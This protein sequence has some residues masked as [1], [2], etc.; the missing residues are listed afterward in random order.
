MDTEVILGV[1]TQHRQ[2]GRS[3]V[4]GGIEYSLRAW[5]CTLHEGR[6]RSPNPTQLPYIKKVEFILHETFEN[7][8]RA[9]KR[10]STAPC[11]HNVVVT[12]APFKVGEE[13]WGEFDL[14]IIVHFINCSETY[15]IVHDLNFH[16]GESYMKKYS[17]TIPDP[18]PGFLVLFNKH[19]SVSRKTIPPRATKARK[20]PPRDSAYA[21]QLASSR[22][23]SHSDSYSSDRSGASD[24]DTGSEDERGA[25]DSESDRRTTSSKTQSVSS[26]SSR[27]G[28][29]RVQIID[30]IHPST[31]QKHIPRDVPVRTPKARS[32]QSSAKS[33]KTVTPLSAQ[34]RRQK[35]STQPFV[36]RSSSGIIRQKR[37]PPDSIK[38][39]ISAASNSSNTAT[40]RVPLIAS[41]SP[42]LGAATA[43][44]VSA[45]RRLSNAG[46]TASREK[47]IS[48]TNKLDR[49]PPLQASSGIKRRLSDALDNPN[50]GNGA[51]R[52]RTMANSDTHTISSSPPQ[53]IETA[54]LEHNSTALK[55]SVLG[56]ISGVK[57]PKKQGVKSVAP[58]APAND[59]QGERDRRSV[60][61]KRS[62]IANG[63]THTSLLQKS[64]LRNDDEEQNTGLS[65]REA[66]VRERERQ[67]HLEHMRE[68]GQT[69]EPISAAATASI[70]GPRT[71]KTLPGA[72]KGSRNGS[73]A[74]SVTKNGRIIDTVSAA[75]GEEDEPYGA[76]GDSGKRKALRRDL[77]DIPIPKQASKVGPAESGSSS[78]I[79]RSRRASS[80]EKKSARTA[81]D[82][83]PTKSVKLMERIMERASFLN[84]S[85]LIAFLQLLHSL[86]V[87]Q[88]PDNAVSITDEAVDRVE[89]SGEYACN[90]STLK[91]MAIDRLWTFIKETCV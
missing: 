54:R 75:D 49:Q 15:K 77:L 74:P 29:N 11:L 63:N 19:S 17:F 60:A 68:S 20:G 82:T 21:K 28:Q 18:T 41:R 80:A 87:E 6:P 39:S 78:S 56:G 73:T 24:D 27:H 35:D 32:V 48:P 70:A 1:H 34:H 79:G 85:E 16:E 64:L 42:T 61:E 33:E 46:K 76:I 50:K 25:S 30:S 36:Q 43:K 52:R 89:N 72:G 2:T 81:E 57:V 23:Y 26:T 9:N 38:S 37:L 55:R 22:D 40:A 10:Y 91:P 3:V 86:R 69:T 31:S 5:S 71:A 4:S 53:Q 13:G 62:A 90:L 51:T 84:E 14:I 83:L 58:L 88:E 67:R 8:H 47:S 44:P 7:P 65:S 45:T 12:R 59:G 66:F